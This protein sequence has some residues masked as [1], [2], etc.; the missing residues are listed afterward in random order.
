MI[1]PRLSQPGYHKSTN[2][3]FLLGRHPISDLQLK[4]ENK[5]ILPKDFVTFWTCKWCGLKAIDDENKLRLNLRLATK[6]RTI[7]NVMRDLERLKTDNNQKG[8]FSTEFC[9]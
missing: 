9:C 5:C 6:Y 3:S 1:V 7:Q 2:C 4:D 8:I